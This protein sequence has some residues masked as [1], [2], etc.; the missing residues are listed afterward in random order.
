MP[1]EYSHYETI[2]WRQKPF[3]VVY[4]DP[5]NSLSGR[6]GSSPDKALI[7][8]PYD[9]RC[10]LIG[11]ES[12]SYENISEDMM[13]DTKV[14]GICYIVKRTDRNTHPARLYQLIDNKA[15]PTVYYKDDTIWFSEINNFSYVP[16][17][18]YI[19]LPIE[20][21]DKITKIVFFI[22]N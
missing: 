13:I 18:N 8:F 1:G 17:Y 14:Y 16:N 10:P 5:E 9:L 4:I 15:T 20:P 6:D 19:A 12:S 21:T 11:D 7:A 22:S 3:I 2:R